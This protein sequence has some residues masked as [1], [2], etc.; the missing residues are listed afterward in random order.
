MP[1]SIWQRSFEVMAKERAL[2]GVR[3]AGREHRRLS[4]S[5]NAD[6]AQGRLAG[7][8]NLGRW[9]MRGHLLESGSA[10]GVHHSSAAAGMVLWKT[11]IDSMARNSPDRD[12]PD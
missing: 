9:R 8:G 5:G 10:A 2:V 1:E 11:V 4:P 7:H 12:H 6:G 3:N